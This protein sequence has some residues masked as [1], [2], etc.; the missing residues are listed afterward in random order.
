MNNNSDSSADIDLSTLVGCRLQKAVLLERVLENMNSSQTIYE[1]EFYREAELLLFLSGDLANPDWHL[2]SKKKYSQRLVLGRQKELFRKTNKKTPALLFL[3]SH[4]VGQRVRAVR[5]ESR[6]PYEVLVISFFEEAYIELTLNPGAGNLSMKCHEKTISTQNPKW[7]RPGR[8]PVPFLKSALCE[9]AKPVFNSIGKQ[10]P[11][12]EAQNTKQPLAET[13]LLKAIAKVETELADKQTDE[14]RNWAHKIETEV[15]VLN[16]VDIPEK[17]KKLI[18]SG[19]TRFQI[20]DQLF[21]LAKK[22]EAKVAGTNK[23]LQQLRQQLQEI[24]NRGPQQAFALQSKAAPVRK[25]KAGEVKE[26]RLRT[27]DL[28]VDLKL[29]IGKSA[30]E[31]LKLLREARPFD[32]WIH[33][34]DE[35]GAY[36]IIRR[37]RGRDLQQSEVVKA[38]LF[39]LAFEQRIQA[40]KLKVEQTG[41]FSLLVAECRYV[42][43][44]KG[45]KGLARYTNEKVYVIRP[46]DLLKAQA[47]L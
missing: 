39:L 21:A 33:L 25:I 45:A 35:V 40:Q 18:R 9:S 2:F 36:G 22:Q 27:F 4:F 1:L 38:A 14:L 24:Q 8:P 44:V 6:P 10:L 13:K 32:L 29:E 34:K 7:M 12:E 17:I 20:V 26:I 37:N 47:E 31:N 19:G 30:V 11:T 3:K 42:R 28:G 15:S 46:K 16:S 41:N 43:P 5:L 23:R